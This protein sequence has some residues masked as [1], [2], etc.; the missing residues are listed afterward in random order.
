LNHTIPIKATVVAVRAAT[1][2][3]AWM[4][5]EEKNKTAIKAIMEM[6]KAT[7]AITKLLWLKSATSHSK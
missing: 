3:I 7:M 1:G 5:L 4:K 2:F 6:R